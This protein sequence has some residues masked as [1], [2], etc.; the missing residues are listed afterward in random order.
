MEK[1]NGKSVGTIEVF[2]YYLLVA[3]SASDEGLL[4]VMVVLMDGG[5]GVSLD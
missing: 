1:R 5:I 2:K 3:I 4:R